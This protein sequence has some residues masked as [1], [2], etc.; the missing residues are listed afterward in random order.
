MNRRNFLKLATLTPL[1]GLLGCNLRLT[2]KKPDCSPIIP[3]YIVPPPDLPKRYR[4]PFDKSTHAMGWKP[5]SEYEG[6]RMPTEWGTEGNV[7][8][9]G[10]KVGSTVEF[11]VYDDLLKKWIPGIGTIKNHFYGK[12]WVI[13]AKNQPG[14]NPNF[15]TW[16]HE[17][18][19]CA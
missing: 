17:D 10:L 4:D 16:V 19:I 1:A 2:T 18:N 12:M 15:R 13:S 3:A 11:R 6:E 9:G 5:V 8:S 7:M 14:L